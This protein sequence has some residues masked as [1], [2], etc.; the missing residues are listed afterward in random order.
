[1][2]R[3]DGDHWGPESGVG[4]T[5]TLVAA[6]RAIAHSRDLIDDPLAALL[7][8]AVGIDFFTKLLDDP[9]VDEM[10]D[11]IVHGM[12]VRTKYF[13]D[14]LLA[15]AGAGIRQVAILGSGL[16]SRTYRLG[17]PAGTVV[18]E[19]DQPRVID[20]VTATLADVEPAAL[21]R[22]VAID[23]RSDWPTALRDAGLDIAAPTA[24]LAEG[25]LIYLPA[26]MQDRLLTQ[27]SELSA[28]GSQLATDHVTD[29]DAFT[30]ERVQEIGDHWRRFYPDLEDLF[31]AG[32]RSIVADYL[33]SHGWQVHTHTATSHVSAIKT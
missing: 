32:Q 10:V 12:V 18:Y 6:I 27:I 14:Y 8:R 4:V 20:F 21:R 3:V 13:D 22:T 25:L 19:I 24:W 11:G 29:P 26:N 9:P 5:A 23:L 16:D 33:T 30:A 28:T 15:A 17:W 2:P 31:F 7:V 1:M